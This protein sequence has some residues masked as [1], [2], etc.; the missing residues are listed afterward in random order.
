MTCDYCE[1]RSADLEIQRIRD[2]YRIGFVCRFCG[3]Y[4][5]RLGFLLRRLA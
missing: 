1:S 2:R 3:P 5:M 4:L